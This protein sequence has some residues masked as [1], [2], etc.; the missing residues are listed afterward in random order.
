MTDL[1]A[2]AV[3]DYTAGT[4]WAVVGDLPEFSSL[5]LQV[6]HNDPGTFEL[7]V[8]YTKRTL[9]LLHDRMVTF[10]WRG[11]RLMTGVIDKFDT[12]T[13]EQ[14]DPILS[15]YG[16]DALCVLGWALAWPDP[17]Q[18]INQQPFWDSADP[19]PLV[20]P[21]E[22]LAL[23]LVR[24]NMVTR[25]AMDLVVPTSLDR[26]T[27]VR[28]RPNFDNLL[29]LVTRKA[30]N[31]GVTVRLGL[32]DTSGSRAALTFWVD[33]PG[34]N[35]S[36]RIIVF[37]PTLDGTLAGWRLS[38]AAPTATRAIV[39]GASVEILKS[40]QT[41][42]SIAEAAKWGGDREVF[43]AEDN[44][45]DDS[46]LNAAGDDAIKAGRERVSVS[47]DAS[48]TPSLQAFRD[49]NVGDT[50]IAEL[51]GGLAVRQYDRVPGGV[52][53]KTQPPDPLSAM[54]VTDT[55]TSIRL[56]VDAGGPQVTLTFGD[57]DALRPD[58]QTAR[59]IRD[60]R[61][62]VSRINRKG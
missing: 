13:D 41:T 56:V 4:G 49:F 12:G 5:D 57:P 50:A 39:R 18:G 32:V 38:Q 33:A 26:G 22:T 14:G 31:G 27:T 62:D 21:A 8:P 37:S 25:R 51:P 36:E 24:Q 45:F 61:R 58:V 60:T 11:Q 53:F 16:R 40:R 52:V 15:V 28:A 35:T 46:D 17:S 44:A 6:R 48:E 2:V 42:D 47:V 55:I 23:R 43:A 29:E 7:T 54:T 9:S 20:F 1:P 30:D 3:W 59:V 34:E 19:A 10:D